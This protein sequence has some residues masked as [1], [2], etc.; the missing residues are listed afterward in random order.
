M[1]AE[2]AAEGQKILFKLLGLEVT[3]A[4]TTMWIVM[5]VIALL[6]WVG[7]RR[8]KKVPSGI[9]NFLEFGVEFLMNFYAGI[10]GRE[11]AKRFIPF[12]MTMFMFILFSNYSGLFPGVGHLTGLQAPTSMLSVPAGFAITV[13]LATHII[14]VREHGLHYFKRFGQPFI[15]FLPLNIIEEFV[16][17]LSLCLRLYGNIYGEEMTIAVLL[18]LIPLAAPVPMMLLSVLM[19]FIQAL[20]FTLLTAVYIGNAV[21]S[22][23]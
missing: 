10:L 17:P 4:V 3:S 23:H 15:F 14:G 16:R 6:A 18:S 5:A 12:L 22:G 1:T 13:F 2:H 8:L 7:T 11:N 9:Q 20:V 19:G 21:S